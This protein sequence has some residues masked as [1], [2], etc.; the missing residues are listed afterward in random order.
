MKGKRRPGFILLIFSIISDTFFFFFYIILL[1][2]FQCECGET[3]PVGCNINT[4]GL[5]GGMNVLILFSELLFYLSHRNYHVFYYLLV[6]AT[7]EERKEYK[8]LQPENYN[9]LKQVST[10]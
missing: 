2:L 7:D 8:L 3:T 6:G 4:T 1:F 5:F 9:Y 10:G